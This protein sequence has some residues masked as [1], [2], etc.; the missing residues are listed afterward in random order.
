MQNGFLS[1]LLLVISLS[2]LS[3]LTVDQNAKNSVLKTDE[4][5]EDDNFV[6]DDREA[7]EIIS[8]EKFH[9]NNVRKTDEDLFFALEDD[10]KWKNMKR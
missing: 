3:A 8:H 9:F 5:F 6:L 2:S 1:L 7:R 4:K 10:N